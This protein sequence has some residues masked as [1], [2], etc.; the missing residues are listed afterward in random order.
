MIF[1]ILLLLCAAVWVAVWVLNLTERD[2]KNKSTDTTTRVETPEKPAI[3]KSDPGVS[4]VH[5]PAEKRKNWLGRVFAS[6]PEKAENY[7]TEVLS[8]LG[9]NYIIFTNVIF[10]KPG[11]VKTTEIDHLVISPFGIFCVETKS[12]SGSIYGNAG[13]K[14]WKQYLAGTG[15]SFYNPLFQNS[16]HSKALGCLLGKRQK[17][18]IH[19]YVVFPYA[20]KVRVNSG[21]VFMEG[22]ELIGAIDAHQR[23]I[24]SRQ[25]LT[26]I[27]YT[28]ARYTSVYK[29]MQE[30]H[31]DNVR[32]YMNGSN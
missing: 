19:N 2:A 1:Y 20:D 14:Y 9:V 22:R 7:T 8:N 13:A 10:D 4:Y 3:P 5:A 15:Y 25:E 24:Y 23:L 28:I 26:D 27:A 31:V 16:N 32:K 17:S 11:I 30:V 6:K 18:K 29:R 21:A 12:H